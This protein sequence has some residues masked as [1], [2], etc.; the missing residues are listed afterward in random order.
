MGGGASVWRERQEV[1]GQGAGADLKGFDRVRN[2]PRW[3]LY[4]NLHEVE[5]STDLADL[6]DVVNGHEQ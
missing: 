1:S 6:A 4:S 2:P 3:I 5:R